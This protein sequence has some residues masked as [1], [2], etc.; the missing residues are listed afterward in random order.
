MPEDLWCAAIRLFHIDHTINNPEYL[1]MSVNM[2][3]LGLYTFMNEQ[4]FYSFDSDL[5]KN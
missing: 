2:Y 3:K 1:I 5:K 4:Y